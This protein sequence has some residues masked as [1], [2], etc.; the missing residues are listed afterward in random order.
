MNRLKNN[1]RKDFRQ[2]K[3]ARIQTYYEDKPTYRVQHKMYQ[4]QKR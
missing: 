1:Q 3:A 2:I 4:I